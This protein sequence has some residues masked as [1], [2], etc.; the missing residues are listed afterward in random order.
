MNQRPSQDTDVRLLGLLSHLQAI[1][2]FLVNS[3]YKQALEKWNDVPGKVDRFFQKMRE[4]RTTFTNFLD[5]RQLY[6]NLDNTD[7]GI[8]LRIVI[9]KQKLV[10]G[11]KEIYSTKNE[12]PLA[13]HVNK[14][15]EILLEV[16]K[17]EIKYKEISEPLE[18]MQNEMKEIFRTKE[19]E[20]KNEKVTFQV[21]YKTLRFISRT[22]FFSWVQNKTTLKKG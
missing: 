21:L 16:E 5:K 12:N 22:R 2:T 4:E 11:Q 15:D 14:N 9:E 20:F 19:Q 8:A 6:S 18:K 3:E 1:N 7:A 10:R 13:A 17:L